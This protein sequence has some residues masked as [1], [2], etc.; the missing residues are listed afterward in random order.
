MSKLRVVISALVLLSVALRAADV[1]PSSPHGQL[2]RQYLDAF[3]GG[4]AA[5]R[6]F[7][8][9]VPTQTPIDERVARYR[10]MKEGLTSLTPVRFVNEDAGKLVSPST[11]EKLDLH[12]DG[13]GIA[14]G[15]PGL[16]ATI[17]TGT[18]SAASAT[19]TLVVM[20]NFDPPSAERLSEQIRG[21]LRPAKGS[22]KTQVRF[23]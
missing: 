7:L 13:M 17:D 3:N 8:E 16:N 2:A 23:F 21:L 11:I 18:P 1:L 15:A 22:A 14:G 10:K 12:P 19:Y 5:M 20:S 9:E 6:A 4:E